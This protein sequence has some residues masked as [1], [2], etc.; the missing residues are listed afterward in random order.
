MGISFQLLVLPGRFKEKGF[1]F[2]FLVNLRF[3]V[4][5]I[6]SG[7]VLIILVPIRHGVGGGK[8]AFRCV[9]LD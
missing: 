6:P 9:K 3:V 5:L 1:A 4:V 2:C 8:Q 7:K